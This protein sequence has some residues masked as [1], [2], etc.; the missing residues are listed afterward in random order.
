LALKK[1]FLSWAST[2]FFVNNF[3]AFFW[4][5]DSDTN[6]KDYDLE[7]QFFVHRNSSPFT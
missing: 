2:E 3:I 4:G 5:Y 1:S 6:T 7:E